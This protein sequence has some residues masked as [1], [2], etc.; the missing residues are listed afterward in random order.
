MHQHPRPL[1]V[2]ASPA[3]LSRTNPARTNNAREQELG[4]SKASSGRGTP[5]EQGSSIGQGSDA[6][7][8]GPET[9]GQGKTSI[10]KL[11]QVVSVR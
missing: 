4:G 3:S 9:S 7:V 1:L 8:R 10:D 6:L 5:S 11:G 2:T